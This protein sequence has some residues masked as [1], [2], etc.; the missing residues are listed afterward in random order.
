MEAL[1]ITRE[2]I[3]RYTVL[4]GNVDVDKYIQFIKAAQDLHLQKYL[5]GKLFKKMQELIVNGDIDNPANEDY[6]TLLVTYLK[7][8]TIHYALLEYLPFAKYTLG[9]KGVFIHTSENG[10]TATNED[11]NMLTEKTRDLAQHYTQRFIDY[12]CFYS[13]LYVEYNQ[14]RNE[15]MYP[16]MKNNFN[17]WQL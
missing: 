3:V 15:D 10:E 4:G 9:N 2:D 17:G 1:F 12:M 5:G 16:T 14:S 13:H 11:I 8:M 6:K 7:P